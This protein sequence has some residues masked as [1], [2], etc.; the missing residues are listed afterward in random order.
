M[1]A[2]IAS[3]RFLFRIE[4]PEPADSGARVPSDRR[5][6][7]ASRLSYFLWSTMPDDEL[8]DLARQGLLRARLRPEVKR[9]LRDPRASGLVQ[10]FTGQWLQARDFELRADQ[11]ARRP[12]PRTAQG[13]ARIEFDVE[14]RKAMRAET[15]M[16]FA[17]VMRGDRSVLELVESDYTFLNE[18][19]A[20]HYGIPGVSGKE[21]RRVSFPRGARA[22]ALLTQGGVLMITSNPSRTSPVKRGQFILENILGTPTPPPPPDVPPLE[23]ASKAASGARADACGR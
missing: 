17:H 15:E 9:M 11:Q 13:P 19:L 16:A 10:N 14:T 20:K 8:F 7:L 3:P 5:L 21:I 1:M 23:D 18:K 12:R 6:S 4:V 2:I 22:A